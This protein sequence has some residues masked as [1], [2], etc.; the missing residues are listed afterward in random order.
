MEAF[1]EGP[2]YENSFWYE[3]KFSSFYAS[4]EYEKDE[5][6]DRMVA[7]P[8]WETCYANDGFVCKVTILVFQYLTALRRYFRKS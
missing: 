4:D 2:D 1:K 8:T 7:A 6:T 5:L 3:Q